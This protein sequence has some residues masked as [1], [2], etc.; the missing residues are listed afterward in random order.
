MERKVNLERWRERERETA[1]LERQLCAD[2]KWV[3]D[4]EAWLRGPI[5]EGSDHEGKEQGEELLASKA[6]IDG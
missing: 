6:K 5:N 2:R 4:R 3:A 1:A